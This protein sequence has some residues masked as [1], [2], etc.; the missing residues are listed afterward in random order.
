MK[1]LESVDRWLGKHFERWSSAVAGGAHPKETLEIRRDVLRGIAVKVEAKGGGE[2]IFPYSEVIVK[3]AAADREQADAFTAAFVDED[4]LQADVREMLTE[5][6]CAAGAVNVLVEVNED[7]AAPP[8]K[9][10]FKRVE[11]PAKGA[12][13]TPAKVR[14]AAWLYVE[15]GH[16]ERPEYFI[17]KDVV[18]LGRLKEVREKEGGLRRR[19]DVAFDDAETTVSREHAHITFEDGRFRLF[20][21][22]GERATRLFRD[23]RVVPLPATGSRGTQLRGGDEIHLGDARLRFETGD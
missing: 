15:N 6:G 18:Y 19:N 1:S 20:H 10:E 23:G 3:L 16:A 4:A 2:Y 11:K 14:P 5:S 21:D 9:L 7:P 12:A 22:S 17:G 13:A 8:F